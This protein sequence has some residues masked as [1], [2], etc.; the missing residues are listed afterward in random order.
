MVSNK[1]KKMNKK[2]ILQPEISII[3]IGYTKPITTDNP[4]EKI[5][6]AKVN[7]IAEDGQQYDY[8][9]IVLWS[10]NEYDAIGQWQDKD[11]NEKI[12]FILSN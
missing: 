4:T 5:V 11:V 12:V 8:P 7:L 3:A 6:K 2:I 9:E 10:G 1:I